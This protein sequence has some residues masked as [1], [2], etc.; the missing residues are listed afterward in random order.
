VRLSL[1][2]VLAAITICSRSIYMFNLLA[3]RWSGQVTF[4]TDY[5]GPHKLALMTRAFDAA[6]QEVEAVTHD[7]ASKCSTLR[8][9]MALKIMAAVKEGERDLGCLTRLALE[10]IS[11]LY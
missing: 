10:A 7:E 5:Y 2:K 6:W 9:I 11:E 1:K 8:R 3:D 4:P